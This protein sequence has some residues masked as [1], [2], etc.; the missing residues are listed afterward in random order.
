MNKI[1]AHLCA[2]KAA[3]R[4]ERDSRVGRLWNYGDFASLK[5]DKHGVDVEVLD[6]EKNTKKVF[7]YWKDGQEKVEIK[8]QD[9]AIADRLA[10][11]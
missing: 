7:R 4:R 6:I 5:L 8:K 1:I 3:R 11:K 2:F 9:A 10:R